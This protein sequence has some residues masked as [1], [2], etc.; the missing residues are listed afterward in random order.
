MRKSGLESSSIKLHWLWD[1][2]GSWSVKEA[3]HVDL[4]IEEENKH[5]EAV[6]FPNIT[7]VES[8]C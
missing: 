3:L 1:A 2:H 7:E 4:L 8:H 5:V 6:E